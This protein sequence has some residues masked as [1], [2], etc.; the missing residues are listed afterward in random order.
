MSNKI[1]DLLRTV[2]VLD[3]LDDTFQ[4]RAM[5]QFRDDTLTKLTDAL[6]EKRR[7]DEAKL[8][9]QVNHPSFT[10]HSIDELKLAREVQNRNAK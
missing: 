4:T 2:S 1:D 6:I 9:A 7:F 10:V 5:R 3:A 8:A